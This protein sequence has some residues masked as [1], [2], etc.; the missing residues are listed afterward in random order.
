MSIRDTGALAG[1]VLRSYRPVAAL[2]GPLT[3]ET[4][5]YRRLKL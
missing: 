5:T 2:V 1:S 3:V 4:I